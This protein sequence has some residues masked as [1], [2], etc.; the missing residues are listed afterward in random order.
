MKIVAQTFIVFIAVLILPLVLFGQTKPITSENY[1]A[2]LN[3][4]ESK[5][6]KQIRKR[7]QIQKLYTNGEIT[8]TLTDTTEYLPPDKSRWI[9]VEDRGN[10]V[11]RIEQITIGNAVY[12]KENT[13]DWLKREK[14]SGG[15]GIGGKDN[16]KREFFIEEAKIGKEKFQVLIEKRVN[17]NNTFFDEVKTWIDKK[18]LILKKLST[19]S[20]NELRN[21]V[22]SV[23]V[24]YDYKLKPPKIEAPIK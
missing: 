13:G 18:G 1:Y 9:S 19:T 5:T 14:D 7:V 8:A 21:I 6:D 23:E 12:R 20:F 15:F 10:V 24:T 3:Q 11:K 22:S 17:Y 4:A 16:S 2:L